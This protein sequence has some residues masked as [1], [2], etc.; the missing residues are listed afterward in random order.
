MTVVCR[1][2]RPA[3]RNGDTE[4]AR[5]RDELAARL[6]P[7]SVSVA[8]QAVQSWS[9]QKQ[10]EAAVEVKTPLGG[11]DQAAATPVVPARHEPMT[12]E[13]K[14]DLAPPRIPQ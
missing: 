5:R 14:L 2:D 4:S 11:W 6:D 3:A 7:R 9:P 1:P 12:L 8:Q 10:P 13:P